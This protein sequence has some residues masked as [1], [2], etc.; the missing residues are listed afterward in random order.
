MR[1]AFPTDDG[2]TINRHFGR[3]SRYAVV[4]IDNGAAGNREM[5]NKAAHHHGNGHNQHGH[6]D[7]GYVDHGHDDHG[8]DD[9]G[10]DHGAMFAPIA[11]CQ[12]LIAGNMGTPA[13]AAAQSTGLEVILTNEPT[14]DGALDAWLAGTLGHRPALLHT[15]GHHH[16]DG[17]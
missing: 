15:P 9:H 16:H 4:I 8:H 17:A 12:V 7:H 2:K 13:Y 1:I 3:A 5:R 11:D 6:V 10:H 14:I